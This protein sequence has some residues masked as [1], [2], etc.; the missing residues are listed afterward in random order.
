VVDEESDP[1]YTQICETVCTVWAEERPD[2]PPLPD[3][4]FQFAK[5]HAPGLEA[6]RRKVFPRARP[7]DDYFHVRNKQKE[8]SCRCNHV[9]VQKGKRIKTHLDWILA[10]LNALHIMPTIELVSEN[11][12]EFLQR[13]RLLTDLGT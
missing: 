10:C 2:A 4:V 8:I 1:N 9:H 11:W 12:A 6:A 5:D 7:V 13:L 3:V